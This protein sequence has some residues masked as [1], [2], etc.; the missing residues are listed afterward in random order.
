MRGRSGSWFVV[1]RTGSCLA[2]EILPTVSA[3]CPDAVPPPARRHLP[4]GAPLTVSPFGAGP[5]GRDCR[6]FG[7]R[8]GHVEVDLTDYGATLVAVRAPDRDGRMADVLLGHDDLAGYL[9]PANPHL[10]ATIGRVANRIGGARF[11]LDD[12][13]FTLAANH[14]PHHLHGGEAGALDNVVWDVVSAADDHVEFAV[15]SPD[16]DEGYPGRLEV[17]VR[18]E[19]AD[20][21]LSLDFRA[22]TDAPTPVNLTSH[23]YFNLGGEPAGR[24]DDHELQVHAAAY[25]PVDG[26]LIPTGEVAEVAGTP[27]DLR[28]PTRVADALAA[29]ADDPVGG[30]D[31]N[32]VVD[33]APGRLRPAAR[34]VHPPSGRSLELLTDQP[35]VQVYTGN[36]LD[37]SV[38]GRGGVAY[39]RHTA[40]CLEP[41]GFPD[42]VNQPTFPSIVLRPGEEYRHRSVYVF[43]LT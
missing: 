36:M 31:H 4:E 9:D 17:G 25:T 3:A 41:Q 1:G 14:G 40:F 18:F 15:V 39:A 30:F 37:G 2:A 28:A 20:G 8:D 32:Y 26:E 43:G 10:G 38:V 13:T 27:L 12:H 16:G 5:E 23:G 24:I 21:R 35:G 34:V 29:Q 33:G 6:R 22:R 19:L 7:L 42:A 11:S